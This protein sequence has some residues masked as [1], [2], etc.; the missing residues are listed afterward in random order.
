M[1]ERIA[2][3]VCV[4]NTMS[5]ITRIRESLM[6]RNEEHLEGA[7][8]TKECIYCVGDSD[9]FKSEFLKSQS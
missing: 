5:F 4:H 1:F 3:F 2:W 7:K 6:R 8:K 9:A